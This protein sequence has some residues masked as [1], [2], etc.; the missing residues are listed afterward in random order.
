MVLPQLGSVLIFV[1]CV[2]TRAHENHVLNHV[3]KYESFA[4][5]PFPLTRE[6][7]LTLGGPGV[8]D[9]H[10]LDMRKLI[11]LPNSS[12]A[13]PLLMKV[14]PNPKHWHRR[15]NSAPHLTGVIPAAGS[16]KPNY[17]SDTHPGL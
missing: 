8:M 2:T 13:L 6:L 7:P 3:L 4:K 11:W 14:G 17:H 10:D 12:T 15:V 9:S 16:E 5:L 1:A